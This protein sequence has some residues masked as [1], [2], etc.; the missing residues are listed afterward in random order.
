[1]PLCWA[2]LCL[3]IFV[4][5]EARAIFGWQHLMPNNY[6]AIQYVQSVSPGNDQSETQFYWWWLVE[7][8]PGFNSEEGAIFIA[9]IDTCSTTA[10]G[11]R[12]AARL[13][14]RQGWKLADVPE[15][16]EVLHKGQIMI[17][18]VAFY[19]PGKQR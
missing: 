1:M 7:L 19:V 11:S 14:A 17:I 4:E 15:N 3:K 12:I 9:A 16:A 13:A 2:F 10:N 18:D 5:E 8:N 6:S